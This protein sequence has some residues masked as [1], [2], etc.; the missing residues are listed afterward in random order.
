MIIC[1]PGPVDL[2]LVNYPFNFTLLIETLISSKIRIKLLF[3]F[4]FNGPNRSYLRTQEQEF[5]GSLNDKRIELRRSEVAEILTV[6]GNRQ[7]A[8]TSRQ[9]SLANQIHPFLLHIIGINRIVTD[10]VHRWVLNN[11]W[12][13]R[14]SPAYH[15]HPCHRSS[16]IICRNSACTPCFPDS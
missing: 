7:S 9:H 12:S 6:A 10:V 16:G 4:Y 2:Y 1:F 15:R 14:L 11:M 5:C 8:Q 3:H 13:H